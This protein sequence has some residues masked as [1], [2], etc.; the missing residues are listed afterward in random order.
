MLAGFL[1]EK[2]RKSIFVLGMLMVTLSSAMEQMD[3]EVVADPVQCAMQ[4]EREIG[5]HG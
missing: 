1:P 3:S 2:F 5:N 4:L